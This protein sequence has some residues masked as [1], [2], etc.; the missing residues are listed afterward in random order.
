MRF[1]MCQRFVAGAFSVLLF[2]C[3]IG[4]YACAN[5][6]SSAAESKKAAAQK[7]PGAPQPTIPPGAK[8]HTVIS[9]SGKTRITYIEHKDG[10]MAAI[11]E[12][13]DPE[14]GK[15]S[16]KDVVKKTIDQLVEVTPGA[17]EALAR[18]REGD[19]LTLTAAELEEIVAKAGGTLDV[20]PV[21]LSEL[22]NTIDEEGLDVRPA[23]LRRLVKQ[24][25]DRRLTGDTLRTWLQSKLP[26][27]KEQ[28]MRG[29][30][31]PDCPGL[32]YGV[33]KREICLPLGALSFAD[34][35]VSFAPG[36]KPSKSPFNKPKRA[37]GEPNYR[38]TDLAD[39]ISIGCNGEL[40]VQFV[41][42]VLV[43][44]EGVDLY[45]FEVGP[46]VEKTALAISVDGIT[47]L[48]IGAIEGARADVDIAGLVQPGERF[49]FV[50]LT[51]AGNSCGGRHSGADIDAIAAV[52][53]EIRLSLDSAVLFEVGKAE[54][55]APAL[56]A[57]DDL[58][59]KLSV[60]G[61]G[62]IITVEGHTD[63]TGSDA[64]NLRLSEARASAVWQYLKTKLT[65]PVKG[66]H[67]KGYGEQ[68]P[69][70][71]NDTEEGRAK[72]RRVDLLVKPTQRVK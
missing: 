47:W 17:K 33:G 41:D 61:D 19:V 27:E 10:Q 42:N 71:D 1:T 39:F 31:T 72:N 23:E 56:N 34:E 35:V 12:A 49:S 48:D 29:R 28:V 51:N 43:D 36:A 45:V 46:F 37:L 15:A 6:A 66:S 18:A 63:S 44:I 50:K 2:N 13:I 60:Y 38:N 7:E 21:V 30:E 32:V 5:D 16:D 22:L 4:T 69:I 8:S 54:L 25:A 14:A 53:A 11:S 59:K 64:D 68:R 9:P 52:G 24:A 3:L 57:I 62:L 26:A 58:A 40:I 70:A 55:K 20:D 67:I 65:I